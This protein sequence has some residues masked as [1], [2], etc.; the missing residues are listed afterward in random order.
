LEAADPSAHGR[1]LEN[2]AVLFPVLQEDL[3]K[4]ELDYGVAVYISHPGVLVCL[5]GYTV[6]Y[7]ALP[8]SDARPG[9]HMAPRDEAP[10]PHDIQNP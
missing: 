1:A 4:A 7:A 6:A 10:I 9:V 8:A 2:A 3:P 5:E